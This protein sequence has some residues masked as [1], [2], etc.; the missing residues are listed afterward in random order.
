MFL[1]ILIHVPEPCFCSPRL[2]G[3]EM[4]MRLLPYLKIPHL[5]AKAHYCCIPTI[6]TSDGPKNQSNQH[7]SAQKA[8][9]PLPIQT[10]SRRF[11]HHL[12][13]QTFAHPRQP[14]R[15]SQTSPSH[16][17]LFRFTPITST[18]PAPLR[19]PV[20]ALQPRLSGPDHPPHKH[21][22]VRVA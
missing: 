7:A 18:L 15:L 5:Q 16:A 13:V 10:T 4:S 12:G 14:G 19:S 20:Q 11:N 3:P 22:R 8:T 17:S 2:P 6:D 9:L 1:P 21:M